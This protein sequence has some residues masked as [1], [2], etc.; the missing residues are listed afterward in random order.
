MLCYV[1]DSLPGITRRKVKRGWAYYDPAGK[2][3]TD[4]GEIDRLNA[5]GMP[6]AYVDC[7]F[8]PSEHGHLQAIGFDDRGRKQ[9]RYHLDFREQQEAAK[10][11]RCA[12]FG[13]A[14]P[15]LRARVEADLA[16]RGVHRDNI[17][18]AVVRLLDLGKVRVG[19]ESY[20]RDNGS[21]GATTLTTRHAEV[22]T[23]RLKL[24]YRGKSGKM[25]RL[26]IADRSLARMVRRCQDL[27]GQKLFQYVGDD[28]DPHAVTSSDVNDYI[29][30]AMGGEFTAKHFRTW[31]ASVIAFQALFDAG[32]E[33]LSLKAM[34][35]PVAAALGNTPAI[36]R[37]SYV[38]PLLIAMAKG[39]AK[40]VAGDLDLPALPGRLPR[41]TRYL[42]PAERGLIALLDDGGASTDENR[43][44]A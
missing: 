11:D 28:G 5:I 9:Y 17:V 41:A 27:P 20:T 14:L 15:L 25:Q 7:W 3:I 39:G 24:E 8:C 43:K 18:A 37:K 2:R 44:A 12:D 32:A 4:R 21:F 30:E 23:A 33:G 42:S 26:T 34:L 1:D 6:P 19:N 35:E 31:G 13:H 10:Y 29:R 22:G 40:F 38:H 36:S 16:A